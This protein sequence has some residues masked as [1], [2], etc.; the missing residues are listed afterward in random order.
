MLSL[1]LTKVVMIAY[2]RYKYRTLCIVSL[3][4]VNKGVHSDFPTGT[5]LMHRA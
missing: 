3:V 2:K 1:M 5:T 4:N